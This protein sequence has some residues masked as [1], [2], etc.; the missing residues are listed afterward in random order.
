MEQADTDEIQV[1]IKSLTP[2]AD[3]LASTTAETKTVT[4]QSSTGDTTT[5]PS[6]KTMSNTYGTQNGQSGYLLSTT[7]RFGKKTVYTYDTKGRVT[8]VNEKKADGTHIRRAAAYTYDAYGNTK[9]AKD[10]LDNTTTY[11]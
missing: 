1:S 11:V 4:T 2:E 8:E 6:G 3:G 7:D 9:T 5:D 10:A